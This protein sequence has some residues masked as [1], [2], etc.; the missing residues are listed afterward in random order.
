MKDTI[1]KVLTSKQ[2]KRFYW[3]TFDGALALLIVILG[4]MSA[5]WIPILTGILIF[6]SKEINNRF[7]K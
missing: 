4:E 6:I 5:A 1:I 3:T 2:A 7:L